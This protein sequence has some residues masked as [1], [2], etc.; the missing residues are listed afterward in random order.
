MSHK[1]VRLRS[2]PHALTRSAVLALLLSAAAPTAWSTALPSA[3]L[4]LSTDV[5][6]DAYPYENVM[7]SFSFGTIT[8]SDGSATASAMLGPDPS[9][10]ASTTGF[11]LQESTADSDFS[12]YFEVLGN[13]FNL[14]TILINS[15]LS[16]VSPV[17]DSPTSGLVSQAWGGLALNDVEFDRTLEGWSTPETPLGALVSGTTNVTN[18][19]LTIETDTLYQVQINAHSETNIAGDTASVSID[20][21]ITLDPADPNSGQYTLEFSQGVTSPATSVS[22]PGSLG[23]YWLGAAMVGLALLRRRGRSA[24]DG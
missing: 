17:P 5:V 12:Y 19:A 21:T 10:F 18:Q 7:K 15:T 16:D 20:P 2:P 14:T 11:S 8:S 3:N 13:P 22:E 9:A 23:L 6:T 1:I 4:E 24:Y